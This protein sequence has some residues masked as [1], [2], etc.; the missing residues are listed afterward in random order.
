MRNK[1]DKTYGYYLRS[2]SLNGDHLNKI[3]TEKNKI[4]YSNNPKELYYV[5]SSTKLYPKKDICISILGKQE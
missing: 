3:L 4:M 1:N 2:M 5:K